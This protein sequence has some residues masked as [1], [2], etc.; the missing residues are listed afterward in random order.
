MECT[1]RGNVLFDK[2]DYEAAMEEYDA[3]LKSVPSHM[4]VRKM[5]LEG[6]GGG[7]WGEQGCN[8]AFTHFICL[9]PPPSPPRLSATVLT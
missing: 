3:A 9:T 7:G 6:E 2:D 1:E 8:S 4:E 5:G